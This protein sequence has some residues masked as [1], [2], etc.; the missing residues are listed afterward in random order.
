MGSSKAWSGSAGLVVGSARS[1]PGS[2]ELVFASDETLEVALGANH[3][4]YL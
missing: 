2:P 3:L 4:N 1:L